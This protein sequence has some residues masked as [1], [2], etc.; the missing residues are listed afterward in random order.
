MSCQRVQDINQV[1]I[2][3]LI[4]IDDYVCNKLV[5][6]RDNDSGLKRFAPE[7]YDNSHFMPNQCLIRPSFTYMPNGQMMQENIS[8]LCSQYE[9]LHHPLQLPSNEYHSA[10]VPQP[11]PAQLPSDPAEDAA[12]SEDKQDNSEGSDKKKKRRASKLERNR[13]SAKQ[14]RKRKKEYLSKLEA[15]VFIAS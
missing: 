10:Q 13:V 8:D 2:L 6:I 4:S 9:N 3:V 1:R 11:L 5:Y 12:Q 15:E 14:C 7:P